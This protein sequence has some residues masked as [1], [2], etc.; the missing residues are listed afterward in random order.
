MNCPICKSFKIKK[1]L[2]HNLNLSNTSGPEFIYLA[3]FFNCKECFHVWYLVDGEQIDDKKLTTYYSNK[4]YNFSNI[5][6]DDLH[7]KSLSKIIKLIESLIDINLSQKLNILEVG[8]GD[9]AFAYAMKKKFNINNYTILEIGNF[10]QNNEVANYVNKIEDLKFNFFDL[11]IMRHT[12]E[13][14]KK[15]IEFLD[16]FSPFLKNKSKFYIEVP[17][18]SLPY[19]KVDEINPEHLHH[20]TH[21]SL[22]TTIKKSQAFIQTS[23]VSFMIDEYFTPNRLI[24]VTGN[25]NNCKVISDN[26]IL[27]QSIA[28]KNKYK[29]SRLHLRG[30]TQ[31]IKRYLKSNKTIALHGA[32]ITLKDYL[33]NEGINLYKSENIYTSDPSDI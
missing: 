32:T 24:A 14:V 22:A 8:G 19:L 27:D 30:M 31:K 3:D 11:F 18:W 15:P 23:D 7:Y 10:K 16:L 17:C 26:L 2:K 5:S 4:K 12:L 20:F 25:I 6:K 33:I 13:H 28:F 29:K 21:S 9:G 1:I